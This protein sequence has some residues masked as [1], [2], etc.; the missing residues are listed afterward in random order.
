[1]RCNTLLVDGGG[2]YHLERLVLEDAV[3]GQR[4]TVPAHALFV[5]IGATPHTGWLPESIC[6]A[7][8]G[9]IV[10]GR[11][12]LDDETPPVGWPLARRPY[13]LETTVPG[14][15]AA[16]DVRYRALKRVASAVGEGSTA[17][18]FIHRYLAEG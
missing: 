14:V 18:T 10:T 2:D 11:E 4:D 5:H 17:I 15:F 12:L 6:R 13:L 16:G 9:Y 7:E 3:T 1:V 8:E